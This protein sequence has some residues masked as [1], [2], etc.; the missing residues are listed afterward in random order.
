MAHKLISIVSAE[1]IKKIA[2]LPVS[3]A[4]SF[5]IDINMGNHK[6]SADYFH[7]TF[8]RDGFYDIPPGLRICIDDAPYG[9]NEKCH[10]EV[11]GAIYSEVENSK[12][13]KELQEKFEERLKKLDQFI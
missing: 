6:Y 4:R 13:Y 11:A 5:D 2:E 8:E 3:E 1:F 7:G 9:L 12:E 10:V